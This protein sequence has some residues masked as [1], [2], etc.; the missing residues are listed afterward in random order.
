MSRQ[1]VITHIGAN[2]PLGT[3]IGM[4]SAVYH[5]GLSKYRRHPYIVDQAEEPVSVCSAQYLDHF[6]PHSERLALLIRGALEEIPVVAEIPYFVAFPEWN[7]RPGLIFEND[8]EG[9]VKAKV[10]RS[11]PGFRDR[12]SFVYGGQSIGFQ[13]LQDAVEKIAG[14]DMEACLI[15]GVDSYLV[16]DTIRW[17]EKTGLLHCED[18]PNGF[19]PGEGAA[20]YILA[21]EARAEREGWQPLA[22]VLGVSCQSE[23]NPFEGEEV[24]TG[25]GLRNAIRKACSPSFDEQSRIQ[26]AYCDMNGD[27]ERANELG[28]LLPQ[29]KEFLDNDI[30]L[31]MPAGKWGDLGA[32]TSP[33]LINLAIAS[34]GLGYARGKRTLVWC[35]SQNNHRGAAFL[36]LL[37]TESQG[38]KW[39]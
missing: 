26:H 19:T 18:N 27:R 23:P 6:L 36:E 29:V 2:T 35:S 25:R 37:T 13:L 39:E 17:L 16:Q 30:E 4:S 1:A 11:V 38:D 22:R 28:F 33:A 12:S 32:G 34:S 10:D 7:S 21:S 14:G 9:R 15:G 24:C 8:L 5:A 31:E 3:R 20:F